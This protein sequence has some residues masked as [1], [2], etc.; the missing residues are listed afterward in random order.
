MNILQ[1]VGGFGAKSGGPSTCIYDLL[2]AIHDLKPT[3]VVDLL[4]P[5]VND[6]DD[7]MMGVGEEWIKSVPND[8]ITPLSISRNMSRF[9]SDSDYDI[10]HTNGLWMHINHVTCLTARKK[11][12]P[13][14]ITPHGMLYAEAL[15]RSY[16]KKLPFKKL[17][18]DNDVKEATC[19]H[20]TC[21]SEM[22]EIR[23]YGYKGPIAVIGNPVYIPPFT[24][25]IFSSRENTQNLT[26]DSC[27]I[28]IGFLGRI[29]PIKRIENILKAISLVQNRA[30]EFLIIGTGD[31]EY[32]SFLK[33][34]ISRLKIE[35]KVKFIGF[36]NGFDKYMQLGMLSALF[37]PSDMENFGMIV[38][39]ALI[40][41]TP[42]M[43]SLGTPWESLNEEQCGWWTDNSP[44][45]IAK[46][47]N[48]LSEMSSEQHFAMGKRGREYILHTFAADRIASQMMCLYRWI[49]KEAPKPDFVY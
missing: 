29:H 24:N 28:K 27:R 22:E 21:K 7:Q 12:K 19:I 8:Y 11:G 41:G 20:A 42:V 45:S 31:R 36:L 46:V 47:I 2:T 49:N 32:E 4:T 17:W 18:F 10:Y 9:L 43:A 34:E 25:E 16:W 23:R 39:E 37:V 15:R 26:F 14:V 40:V 33:C 48:E 6:S 5:E 44:E 30:V 3:P 1:T 13:Y 38:P 35:N